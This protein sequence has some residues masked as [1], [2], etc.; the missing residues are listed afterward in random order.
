MLNKF[1]LIA[2]TYRYREFYA[3]DEM[4]DL[5]DDIGDSDSFFEVTN[6]SG[7]IT[8]NTHLDPFQVIEKF[9]G[10]VR[11]EDWRFRYVLRVIPIE[12]ITNSNPS[13]IA[14]AAIELSKMKMSS[15]DSFKLSVEKRHNS[16]LRSLEL[17]RTIAKEIDNPVDLDAPSW[18]VLI[19]ILGN[20]TGIAVLQHDQ[21]FNSTFEKRDIGTNSYT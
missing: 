1:N 3:I 16:S 12:S 8:G 20:V 11:S 18:T 5:L 13:E 6:I 4:L 21:I 19:E 17:I 10:I 7:L 15:S 9:K 14:M 2:T